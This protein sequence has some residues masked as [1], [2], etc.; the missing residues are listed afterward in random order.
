[1]AH[2]RTSMRKSCEILRHILSLRRPYHAVE[3]SLGVSRSLICRTLKKVRERGLTWPDI[4]PLS[5]EELKLAPK[6]RSGR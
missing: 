2:E 5:D 4:E 3:R 6:T 1:M